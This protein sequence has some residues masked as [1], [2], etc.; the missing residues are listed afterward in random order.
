MAESRDCGEFGRLYECAAMEEYTEKTPDRVIWSGGA[1]IPDTLVAYVHSGKFVVKDVID[2]KLSYSDQINEAAEKGTMCKSISNHFGMDGVSVNRAALLTP[3]VGKTLEDL[4][5][6]VIECKSSP[7]VDCHVLGSTIALWARALR[8]GDRLHFTMLSPNPPTTEVVNTFEE[9]LQHFAIPREVVQEQKHFGLFPWQESMQRKTAEAWTKNR[10]AL[11]CLPPGLGKTIAALHALKMADSHFTVRLFCAHTEAQAQQTI[12]EAEAFGIRMANITYTAS[13]K[14]KAGCVSESGRSEGGVEDDKEESDK[15]ESDKEHSGNKGED[16]DDDAIEDG[17]DSEDDEDDEGGGG[18]EGNE[19]TSGSAAALAGEQPE[20][21]KRTTRA[22]ASRVLLADFERVLNASSKT[23][24][25]YVVM[26]HATLRRLM[27]QLPQLLQDEPEKRVALVLDEAHLMKRS[28]EMVDS[29]KHIPKSVGLLLLSATMPGRWQNT[30]DRNGHD[31]EGLLGLADIVAKKTL[32]ECIEMKRL[33]PVEVDLVT[34]ATA[35]GEAGGGGGGEAGGEAGEEVDS[36]KVSLDEKAKTA[37]AWIVFRNLEFTAVYANGCKEAN[38]FAEKIEVEIK[39][40]SRAKVWAKACSSAFS[41]GRNKKTRDEFKTSTLKTEAVQ[42]RVLVSVQQLREGY[43][44]PALQAVIMLSPSS[45]LD[46]VLQTL[47]RVMR[48]SP[49]KERGHVLAFGSKAVDSVAS[50]CAVYDQQCESITLWTCPTS[51][52]GMARSQTPGDSAR[53]ERA[54]K[55]RELQAKAT[56]KVRDLVLTWASRDE[57]KT[58]QVEA[59][60]AQFKAEKL[61]QTSGLTFKY[62]IGKHKYTVQAGK[63]LSNVRFDWH[64]EGVALPDHL[65][66]R[67]CTELPWFEAPEKRVQSAKFTHEDRMGQ[68][69][70]FADENKRLPSRTSPYLDEKQLGK[71][72]ADFTTAKSTSQPAARK[73]LGDAAVDAFLKRLKPLKI[74]HEKRMGQVEAFADENKRLPS[75]T[76]PDLDEKQLGAWLNNFTTAK[77]YSQPAARKE[78]GDAAVDAFLKRVQDTKDANQANDAE[79]TVASFGKLVAFYAKHHKFPVRKDPEVGS[80]YKNMK[81]GQ[82]GPL[83]MAGAWALV[84]DNASLDT[85]EKEAL[86]ALLKESSDKHP[87]Y[88]DAQAKQDIKRKRKREQP[89]HKVHVF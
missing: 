15:E 34:A 1:G 46:V 63:W 31:V 39:K 59:F 11:A 40:L 10:K 62:K 30:Q 88:K 16:N 21:S 36:D 69:E 18:E 44:F 52:E 64:K 55:S 41:A 23:N 49:K 77:S 50:A 80:V 85:K 54:V 81:Q 79:K 82:I 35:G 45:D 84:A 66:Q 3:S 43:N 37:A 38:E 33:V 6:R 28:A 20:Q 25:V 42:H 24:P 76:S 73:E 58:A 29:L 86:H 72:L 75:R 83:S 22:K 78:L 4:Q 26:C 71:W 60:V 57:I 53:A 87:K 47:G 19:S 5:L 67:L 2:M 8:R 13:S 70:A 27:E 17:D 89:L 7:S 61:V 48:A 56:K 32:K 9:C 68:V 74:T 12:L 51:Y 14:R 65:K